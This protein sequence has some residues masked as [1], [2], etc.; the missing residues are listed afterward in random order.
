MTLLHEDSLCVLGIKSVGR[1]W[2]GG[3]GR[4]TGIAVAGLIRLRVSAVGNDVK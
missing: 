3:G 2:W 4:G 1:E